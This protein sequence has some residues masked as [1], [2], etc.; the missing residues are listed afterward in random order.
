MKKKSTVILANAS[1][2]FK[3]QGVLVFLCKDPSAPRNACHVYIA[4]VERN[5]HLQ[6]AG[7][8]QER[9]GHSSTYQMQ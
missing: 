4:S 2:L 6:P 3:A 8:V 9:L 1:S 7:E 5:H